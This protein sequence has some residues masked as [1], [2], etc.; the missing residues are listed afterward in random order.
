MPRREPPMRQREELVA[1]SI[2]TTARFL[3]LWAPSRPRLARWHE[4]F[5]ATERLLN[6][7]I[8]EEGYAMRSRGSGGANAK[9]LAAKLRER[10]LLRI[11]GPGRKLLRNVAGAERAL[12]VPAKRANPAA[13]LDAAARL[14]TYLKPKARRLFVDAGFEPEFWAAFDAARSAL[15]TATRAAA[16]ERG[17]RAKL[18]DRARTLIRDGRADI[19]VL[20]GVLEPFLAEDRVMRDAWDRATRVPR[21]L[22]R[23]TDAKRRRR[24]A[25]ADAKAREQRGPGNPAETAA[26][27]PT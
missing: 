14:S 7:L 4:K 12:R 15:H 10:F 26:G 11:A 8:F 23:P 5:L 6:E 1:E 21:T 22:G 27:T 24:A 16:L 17:Q 2:R 9:W 25:S 18:T 19:D 3:D 20:G 13:I